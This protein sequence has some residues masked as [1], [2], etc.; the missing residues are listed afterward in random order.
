V[1]VKWQVWNK[2]FA[3][4]YRR[5]GTYQVH[6]EEN[7]ARPGDIVVIKPCAKV[8]PQKAF[9]VR[10]IVRQAGRFD[11][12]DEMI[13][14]REDEV[15]QSMKE[16]LDRLKSENKSLFEKKRNSGEKADLIRE[17]KLKAMTE[18]F[19]RIKAR[20]REKME[21]LAFEETR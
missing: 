12:W 9:Y 11:Y 6:D 16:E 10:N 5:T 18:A 3:I 1:K 7:F 2:K 19:E 20:E 15:R 13:K 4:Y 21:N 14:K 8:S 17:R